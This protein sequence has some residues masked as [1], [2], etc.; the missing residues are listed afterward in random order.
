ME[1]RYDIEKHN[2]KSDGVS[3]SL[4]RL[5]DRLTPDERLA[6]V[7]AVAGILYHRQY[8]PAERRAA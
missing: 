7:Q 8:A 1:A 5:L 6:A 4:R 2:V 3:D